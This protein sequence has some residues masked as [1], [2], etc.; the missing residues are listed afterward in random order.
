M[1]S[2]A[3]DWLLRPYLSEQVSCEKWKRKKVEHLQKLM[4][5]HSLFLIHY[6]FLENSYEYRDPVF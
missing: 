5:I 1:G 3:C 6:I 2:L 4:P